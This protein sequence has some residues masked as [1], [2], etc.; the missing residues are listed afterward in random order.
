LHNWWPYV[1][2]AW[3]RHSCGTDPCI[4]GEE[5]VDDRD[6]LEIGDDGGGSYVRNKK[7]SNPIQITTSS[8]TR[9]MVSDAP[10]E[11]HGRRN[12]ENRI[13]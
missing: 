3:H 11:R 9:I 10:P 6:S 8:L 2:D 1:L 7:Q 12:A 5:R 13:E 4:N